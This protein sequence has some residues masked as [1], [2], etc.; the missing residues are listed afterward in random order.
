ML[1][2]RVLAKMAG[3]FAWLVAT[4]FSR[5]V[6]SIPASS[7]RVYFNI[8]TEIGLKS[9]QIC[10]RSLPEDYNINNIICIIR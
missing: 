6:G 7:L 1:L 8:F 4:L 3:V 10:R 5:V 2:D 9:I